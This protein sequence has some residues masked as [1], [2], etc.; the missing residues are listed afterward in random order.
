MPAWPIFINI[1][2]SGANILLK[3]YLNIFLANNFIESQLIKYFILIDVITL[4]AI[5]VVGLKDTL[6]RAVSTYGERIYF[7]FLKN[8][9][10]FFVVFLFLII[11]ISNILIS[12]YFNLFINFSFVH[13]LIMVSV[14]IINT[15]LMDVLLSSRVYLTISYLEFLKGILFVFLF[16]TFFRLFNLDSAYEFLVLSFIFSNLLITIWIFPQVKNIFFKAKNFQK[17]NPLIIDSKMRFSFMY[18]FGFSSLEYF[19]ASLIIYSSSIIMLI[20]FGLENVGDLQV[21]ARP[22]YLALITVLSFPIF[23]FMFPEF[24]SLVKQNNKKE[25]RKIKKIFNVIIS[26][27]GILIVAVCWEFSEDFINLLFPSEYNKSYEYLNILVI[28]LPFVIYT[29]FLFAIIKSYEH[30]K[31]TFLI[32]L[33]GLVSFLISALIFYSFGYNEILLVYSILLSS[34]L[35]FLIS[36]IYERKI[37]QY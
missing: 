11:L 15:F 8:F 19:F 13:M 32:R 10:V 33:I 22:I 5:F 36:L 20:V 28:S 18:S 37:K 30:F 27:V 29:S 9:L 35:M 3:F 14:L 26:V 2:L 23:R 6:I 21:V 34:I 7:F 25:I 24:A 17:R 4:L 31:A 1:F 12:K 16:F